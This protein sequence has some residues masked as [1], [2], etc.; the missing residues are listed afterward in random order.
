[1]EVTFDGPRA[2]ANGELVPPMTVAGRLGLKELV[3]KNMHLGGAPSQANVGQ[4]TMALVA[5]A[6]VGADSTEGAGV[7][8]T[9]R[10]DALLGHWVPAASTPGT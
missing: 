7:L 6:L 9:G 5:C 1:M 8:P 10:A 2:V 4:K 3:G